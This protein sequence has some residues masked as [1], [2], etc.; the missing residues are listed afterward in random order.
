MY[1]GLVAAGVSQLW[2]VLQGGRTQD[3]ASSTSSAS[4]PAASVPAS[5]PVS[6]VGTAS[7]AKI[8]ADLKALLLDLQSDQGGTAGAAATSGAS[9]AKPAGHHHHHSHHA[10]AALSAYAQQ[11]GTAS[12]SASIT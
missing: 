10:Q 8:G 1:A 9:A 5:A 12:P 7:D 4:A 6:G 3:S 2:Q 11:S